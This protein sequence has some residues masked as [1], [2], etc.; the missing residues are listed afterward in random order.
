VAA[1]PI[2]E[3]AGPSRGAAV[4]GAAAAPPPC[5]A[6]RASAAASPADSSCPR[7]DFRKMKNRKQMRQEK[8]KMDLT[9]QHSSVQSSWRDGRKGIAVGVRITWLEME[10]P[11]SRCAATLL[12]LRFE[13]K[14]TVYRGASEPTSRVWRFAG[15]GGQYM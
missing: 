14:V 7:F 8:K 2:S 6:T 12:L 3:E 10:Q 15:G 11:G 9:I 4:W 5:S 13:N 1:G